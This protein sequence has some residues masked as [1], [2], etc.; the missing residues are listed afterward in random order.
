VSTVPEAYGWIVQRSWQFCPTITNDIVLAT[1]VGARLGSPLSV[2]RVST[3]VD[4]S[5][6]FGDSHIP[7]LPREIVVQQCQLVAFIL[8]LSPCEYPRLA[9]ENRRGLIVLENVAGSAEVRR[10]QAR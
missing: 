10:T 5:T 3:S 2:S 7:A 8:P 1:N 6:E 4:R 9:H